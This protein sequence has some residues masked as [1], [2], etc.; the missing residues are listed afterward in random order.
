MFDRYVGP[1]ITLV[2]ASFTGALLQM[3]LTIDEVA[4]IDLPPVPDI[5]TGEA[6]DLTLETVPLSMLSL[7]TRR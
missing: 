4:T 7:G 3:T 2:R 6:L 1:S 5:A